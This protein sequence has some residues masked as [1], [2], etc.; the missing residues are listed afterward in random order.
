MLRSQK[1]EKKKRLKRRKHVSKIIPSSCRQA[2]RS[3][4]DWIDGGGAVASCHGE[5]SRITKWRSKCTQYICFKD[6]DDMKL[7]KIFLL[8][9][10]NQRHATRTTNS[11]SLLK[12]Q[13]HAT[14]NQ[15]LASCDIM[16]IRSRHQKWQPTA[17]NRTA[18]TRLPFSS[19]EHIDSNGN[20]PIEVVIIQTVVGVD[21][22]LFD[23]SSTDTWSTSTFNFM[24]LV[25][26]SVLHISRIAQS[27]GTSEWMQ[28]AWPCNLLWAVVQNAFVAAAGQNGCPLMLCLCVGTNK[29]ALWRVQC[30]QTRPVFPARFQFAHTQAPP[31]P[32][33]TKLTAT[34]ENL[35]LFSG[36]STACAARIHR[37]SASTTIMHHL[38]L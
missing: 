35:N 38:P 6:G 7:F 28:R 30:W 33:I 15:F 34:R 31:E 8:G 5:Q 4:C 11:I 17:T 24:I 2:T 10:S 18:L 29:V 3:R 37:V 25:A 12:N 13:L 1:K 14:L 19:N 32:S 9:I 23:C 26:L 16:Q 21:A 36:P 20:T 27:G 22:W